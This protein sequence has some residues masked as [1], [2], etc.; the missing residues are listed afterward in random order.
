MNFRKATDDLLGGIS[1]EELANALGVSIHTIR[2]ARLAEGA[3]AHRSPPEG[4]EPIVARLA[5]QRAERF[6]RLAET[7]ARRGGPLT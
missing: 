7:L 1:H 6:R 5:K 2:Q 4:W 3:R